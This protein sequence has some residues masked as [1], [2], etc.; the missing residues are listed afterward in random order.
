LATERVHNAFV[1]T[2]MALTLFHGH[3]YTANPLA[4]AA[5]N[6]GLDLLLGEE[7]Q[8]AI[9]R[10]TEAQRTF[11]AT[12]EGRPRVKEPRCLATIAA[13]DLEVPDSGYTSSVR[14]RVLRFF[15]ARGI[16]VRPLGNVLYLIPP[17]C[18][19]REALAE[20]HGAMWEFLEGPANDRS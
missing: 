15:L 13:F 3:S 7:C 16:L 5:A 8:A 11:I 10:I 9:Q 6:A 17:Y 1:G 4:C 18:V 2:D 20:T 12:L 14:E 19:P